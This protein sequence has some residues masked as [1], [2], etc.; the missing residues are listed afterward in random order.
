MPTYQKLVEVGSKL[1][2]KHILLKYGL[3]LS[4]V[5]RR[6]TGKLIYVS[7]DLMNIKIKIP[8]SYKNRNYINSIFGGSMFSAADPILMI[9]LINLLGNDYVVWDKSATISFKRPARETL[10]AEYSYS[11]EELDDI[12]NRI[13]NKHEIEIIKTAVLTDKAKTKIYSE[14]TKTIYIADKSFY[15]KKKSVN[16]SG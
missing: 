5:Y 6:S 15:K 7:K 8:L 11:Q 14:I 4:P 2:A 3:N 16:H 1:I 12:K 9:Q 10:Y 13:K